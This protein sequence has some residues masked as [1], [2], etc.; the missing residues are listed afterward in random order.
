VETYYEESERLVRFLA[1]TDK[2][3]FL[4]LLDALCRH[5][6]F[7]VALARAYGMRWSNPAALEKEFALSLRSA[8]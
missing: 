4:V 3:K 1:K 8:P 6:P 2:A 7:D 5:E